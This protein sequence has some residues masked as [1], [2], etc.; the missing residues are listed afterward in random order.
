M[1]RFVARRVAI[2]ALMLVATSV[3]VFVVLRLLPGD[4][5]ITRL[6]STP[7]VDAELIQRLRSEAGLDDPVAVQYLDWVGGLLRGDF[8]QSYFNQY[9]VGELIAQRLPATIELTVVA[10]VLALVLAVPTGIAAALR[11]GG[12]LDRAITAISTAGM[13]MPQFLIGIVLIVVFAVRL[14][15]FPA[16]GYVP[17]S[18]SPTDNLRQMVLPGLTLAIAAAPLLLRFLRTSMIEVLGSPYIRTAEGKGASRW[19]VVIGHG[20]RNALIPGLTMLGLVVGYTLGGVVIIEYVFGFPGLGSLAIDAVF[21]RDYAILQSVVLL[22]SAM[23]I[24]TTL[25]VD[26]LYGVLDP[27]LRVGRSRD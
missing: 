4:P 13:A 7:G 1:S 15:W 25:A 14:G 11:P 16:R 2:S 23:F 3:L 6:G 27:R 21:K 9:S 26:L 8:G 5:V 18:E 24:L 12:R 19:G 20:F 17:F 22:I 10:I